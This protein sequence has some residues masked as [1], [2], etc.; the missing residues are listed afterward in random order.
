ML[1]AGRVL[2]LVPLPVTLWGARGHLPGWGAAILD[3]V[4]SLPL[5]DWFAGWPAIVNGFVAAGVIAIGGF[6]VWRLTGKGW[7]TSS[8][9]MRPPSSGESRRR[10]MGPLRPSAGPVAVLLPTGAIAG[11][12]IYLRTGASSSPTW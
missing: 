5:P 1:L 2:F 8:P 7:D 11:L 6:V 3:W 9:P 12:A 4:D 10:G